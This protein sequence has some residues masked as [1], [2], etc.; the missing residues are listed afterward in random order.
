MD[1][2]LA[3]TLAA[4]PFSRNQKVAFATRPRI[5]IGRFGGEAIDKLSSLNSRWRLTDPLPI[6]TLSGWPTTIGGKFISDQQ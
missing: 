4:Y 1:R 6:Q 2:P 5:T 3:V